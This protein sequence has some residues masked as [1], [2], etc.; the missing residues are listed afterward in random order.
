MRYLATLYEVVDYF[1][2][3]IQVQNPCRHLVY[4]CLAAVWFVG[5]LVIV[6]HY[7]DATVVAK[8]EDEVVKSVKSNG[9]NVPYKSTDLK[10]HDYSL[11]VE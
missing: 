11:I 1:S 9:S 8:E 10:C 2:S 7:N 4:L 3:I 6:R 5:A